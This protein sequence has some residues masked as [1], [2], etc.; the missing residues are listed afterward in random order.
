V[1]VRKPKLAGFPINPLDWDR[2]D[3]GTPPT[4][5]WSLFYY[6]IENLEAN[7]NLVAEIVLDVAPK[8]ELGT[9][10]MYMAITGYWHSE[11]ENQFTSRWMKCTFILLALNLRASSALMN[12]VAIIREFG[13][14]IYDHRAS[15]LLPLP[16]PPGWTYKLSD[17]LPELGHEGAY[18]LGYVE[19]SMGLYSSNAQKVILRVHKLRTVEF[20][21]AT[22]DKIWSTW[23]DV[24]YSSQHAI[25]MT[26]I[27][28]RP[29]VKYQMKEG[30][31]CVWQDRQFVLS[32]YG[33]KTSNDDVDVFAKAVHELLRKPLSQTVG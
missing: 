7:A 30:V 5:S 15:E 9:Y 20:A 3:S 28:R 16:A 24:H 25:T 17:R 8:A 26:R 21:E 12:A 19:G 23:W 11:R 10:E 29:A 2:K 18:P 31:F 14:V 32:I 22:F 6:G 27:H 4:D 13:N 1:V 33:M